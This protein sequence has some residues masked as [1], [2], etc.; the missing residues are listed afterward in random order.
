MPTRQQI[1]LEFDHQKRGGQS[2]LEKVVNAKWSEVAQKPWKDLGK[3]ALKFILSKGAGQVPVVGGGISWLLDQALT[4]DP[5]GQPIGNA[6]A[7]LA[8]VREFHAAILKMLAG[9]PGAAP[10]SGPESGYC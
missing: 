8:V 3:D 9:G 10:G 2:A 5:P 4:E 7:Q 1:E 6:L